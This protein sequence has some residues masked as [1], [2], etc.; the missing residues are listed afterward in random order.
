[1]TDDEKVAFALGYLR[2]I[3]A[4]LWSLDSDKTPVQFSA[5]DA[6]FYD[7]QVDVIASHVFVD[8]EGA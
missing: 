7:Q 5:D 8:K 3:S 4:V 2:G 6:A 1:M